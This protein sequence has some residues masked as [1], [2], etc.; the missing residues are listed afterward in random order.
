M[1]RLRL[2]VYELD[3][4][5]PLAPDGTCFLRTVRVAMQVPVVMTTSLGQKISTVA[6]QSSNSPVTTSSGGA[7]KVVLQTIPTVVPAVAENG[8]KI[9]VQLAKIITIPAAQLAQ[10]KGGL[11]G[12][13]GLNLVGAPLAVQALAPMSVAPG[14]QVVRLAMPAHQQSAG[15]QVGVQAATQV[16]GAIIRQADTKRESAGQTP[17]RTQDSKVQEGVIAIPATVKEESPES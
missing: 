5:S 16:I 13:S 7:T 14:T 8:E 11:G 4:V 12:S 17:T 2:G 15:S 3:H 6:V 9:T 1:R 10:C